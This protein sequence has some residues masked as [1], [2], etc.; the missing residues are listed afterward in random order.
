MHRST[1]AA[2]GLIEAALDKEPVPDPK[3]GKALAKRYSSPSSSN[4]SHDLSRRRRSWRHDRDYDAR[5]ELTQRKIDKSRAR[6]A[7][8][9]DSEEEDGELCGAR[10]YTIVTTM[11]ATNSR[12]ARST[13][14][15]HDMLGR[16]TRKKK[17][18]SSAAPDASADPSGKSECLKG[19][20]SHRRTRNLTVYRIPRSGWKITSPQS[21]CTGAVGVP[22][23]NACSYSCKVQ[24]AARA[25]LNNLPRGSIRSWDEL[26]YSFVRNFKGTYKRPA[27]IEVLRCCQQKSGESLRSYIQRW[28][29]IKNSAE[30]ISEDHTITHST[31]AFAA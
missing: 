21:G 28:S 6:H 7:R 19:L 24:G 20:N 18:G 9:T 8:S 27:S 10:C 22:P 25:W 12:S 2:L 26:V 30:N 17:M 31:V 3:K 13:S 5:D 15:G 16:L 4:D 1:I 23:C 29:I 11:H 14:Q